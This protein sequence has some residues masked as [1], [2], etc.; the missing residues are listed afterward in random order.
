M[1]PRPP[2]SARSQ[3]AFIAPSLRDLAAA[4]WAG[5]APGEGG[6]ELTSGLV[7]GAGPPPPVALNNKIQH[8]LLLFGAARNKRPL[9]GPGGT[10]NKNGR[11]G[12]SSIVLACAASCCQLIGNKLTAREPCALDTGHWAAHVGRLKRT[13]GTQAKRL[14]ALAAL[15]QFVACSSHAHASHNS[16]VPLPRAGQEVA[17]VLL[18]AKQRRF[19]NTSRARKPSGRLGPPLPPPPPPPLHLGA[20][21][22][23]ASP[24]AAFERPGKVN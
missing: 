19:V 5:A 3:S 24:F 21:P 8:Y 10:S 23:F 20:R 4:K 1:P 17:I 15:Q 18:G 12:A 11:H 9:A 6:G 2:G 7:H 22:P 16:I 13:S 14:I